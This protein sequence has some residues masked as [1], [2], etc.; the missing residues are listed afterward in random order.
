MILTLFPFTLTLPPVT[1]LARGNVEIK[2]A[3]LGAGQSLGLVDDLPLAGGGRLLFDGGEILEVLADHLFDQLDLRQVPDRV[4]AHQ[5]AVAQNGDLVA[6]RVDLLEEVRHEDD[7]DPACLQFAHQPEEH[8]HFLVVQRGGR[9]VEDQH[10]AFGVHRARDGHHLL[11]GE[12][13]AAELLFR[14]GR[15]AQI[16]QQFPGVLLHLLPV[17]VLF[18]AAADEHVFRYR[19]IRAE[20]DLLVDGADAVVLSLLGRPDADGA[21]DAVDPDLSLVHGIYAGQ[22]LDQR[23]FA[24]SVLS[25]QRVDRSLAQGK[26]HVFQGYYAWEGFADPAHGQYSVFLHPL[27]SCPCYLEKTRCGP[28]IAP[29]FHT[30]L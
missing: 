25:H 8:L 16:I 21:L 15:D 29:L 13:T 11:H 26:I 24:S 4:F 19:E 6:D 17:D 10:L 23:G 14:P 7:A 22:H 12:R 5:L 20:R 27:N 2:G 30:A 9:L 28:R 1:C 18:L 3:A